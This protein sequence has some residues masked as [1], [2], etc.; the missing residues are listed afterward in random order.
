LDKGGNVERTALITGAS[1][2]IGAAFARLLAAEERDLILVARREER[3]TAL[4][5]EISS[6]HSVSVEVLP[7]D[8]ASEVGIQRVEK[9]I[10]EGG[11]IDLLINNAG[12]GTRPKDFSELALGRQLDMVSVHILASIRFIKAV[13]PG[14]IS[15]KHGGIINV[16]SVAAFVPMK[17]NAT[18][19]AS[20]AFLDAFS[21]ALSTEL[22]G[23]KV[24]VQILC[25][26]YTRTEFHETPD[27]EGTNVKTKTPRFMW[28]SAEQVAKKSLKSLRHGGL[29]CVPGL[30]N[31]AIVSL[32][33][34]G[35]A[36]PTANLFVSHFRR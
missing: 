4:A 35:V 20:K 16:A 34:A 19:C 30:K 31:K 33:K 7:A 29:Y 2:G 13:L 10:S 32:G 36:A 23:T 3:L 14:M 8:L 12:F 6:R 27:Y 18:Y 22:K 11:A 1:S 21:R 24:K 17:G 15:R 26:G 9:R 25:P 5:S 28:M